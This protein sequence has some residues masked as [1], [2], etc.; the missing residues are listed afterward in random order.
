MEGNVNSNQNSYEDSVVIDQDF[1][2]SAI[3]KSTFYSRVFLYFGLGLLVT[4]GVAIAMS[5]VFGLMSPDSQ[6]MFYSIFLVV[7]LFVM[8]GLQFMMSMRLA[9]PHG[10]SILVPYVVY[11]VVYGI[12]FGS[13]GA[14]VDSQNGALVI[15]IA[16][17]MTSLIFLAMCGFGYLSHQKMP[18]LAKIVSTLFIGIG[19]LAL[20]NFV[21]LPF[22][23]FGGNYAVYYAN[24]MIYWI[25]EAV[26]FAVFLLYTMIDFAR[27]RNIADHGLANHTPNVSLF[28]AFT[29]YTDFIAIFTYVLRFVL[30][31]M[32]N[33]DN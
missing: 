15:G 10:K 2:S 18:Q 28:C 5:F 6:M 16:L 30:I 4:A 29:I 9:N 1:S 25:T 32:A 12:M 33:R 17:G 14:L 23:L 24:G 11:A 31:A 20:I 19:L 8:I 3:K 22:A 13:I 26:F 7:S 27:I 21:L